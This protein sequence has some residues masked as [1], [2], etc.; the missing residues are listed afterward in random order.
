MVSSAGGGAQ[1]CGRPQEIP[2]LWRA[3]VLSA[4]LAHGSNTRRNTDNA[5][6]ISE[7]YSLVD[8]DE[9]K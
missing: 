9:M 7:N 2:G 5:R 4:V 1:L 6:S 3:G 8:R